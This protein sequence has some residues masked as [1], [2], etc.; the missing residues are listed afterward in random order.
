MTGGEGGQGDA[1][2]GTCLTFCSA[3]W[4]LRWCRRSD[5]TTE[6]QAEVRAQADSN[7]HG[8]LR[9]LHGAIAPSQVL[10]QHTLGTAEQYGSE[11]I[12]GDGELH[13]FSCV[14]NEHRVDAAV[15]VCVLCVCVCVCDVFCVCVCVCVSVCA[16]SRRFVCG[17]ALSRGSLLFSKLQ[18]C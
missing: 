17:C 18:S 1:Y 13:G 16:V 7:H 8:G 5:R 15:C 12:I 9:V 2:T 3:M 4:C 14:P 10:T 11:L 6:A